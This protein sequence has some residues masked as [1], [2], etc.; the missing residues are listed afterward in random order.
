MGPRRRCKPLA[1]G[2]CWPDV[3]ATGVPC[4]PVRPPWAVRSES[5]P[6]ERWNGGAIRPALEDLAGAGAI[7]ALLPGTRSPEAAA[8]IAVFESVR[9]HLP[10]TLASC[11][12]GVELIE[13][14]FARD[15]ELA[16]DLDVETVAPELIEGEFAGASGH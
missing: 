13:Q 4:A 14:G 3:F 6:P 8:A 16:S 11:S 15:V 9:A 5:F 2:T 1:G 10:R 7:A 12:S